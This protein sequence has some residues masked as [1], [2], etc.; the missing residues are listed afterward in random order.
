MEKIRCKTC[1]HYLGGGC[2]EINL[3]SECR[4]GGGFE[5]FESK[6]KLINIDNSLTNKNEHDKI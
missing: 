3:E 2:C 1:S 4:E 6:N 5:A